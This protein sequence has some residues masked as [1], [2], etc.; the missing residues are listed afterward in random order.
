MATKHTTKGRASRAT[1]KKGKAPPTDVIS[2]TDDFET[3]ILQGSQSG[4]YVLKLYVTGTTPR[5]AQA[6]AS[7]RTLCE[8]YLRGRYDLEVI[9]IY[10]QPGAAAVE[11]IIAAPTLIKQEP[12]PARRIV[13]NLGDKDKILLSLNIKPDGTEKGENEP[14]RWIKV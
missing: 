8:E 14:T 2:S 1:T 13:G 6:V 7:I 10:Q 3:L 5:A 4:H 11:Q 9:D 12:A